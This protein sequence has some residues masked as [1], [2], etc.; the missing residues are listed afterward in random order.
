MKNKAL[1]ENIILGKARPKVEIRTGDQ[2]P[3][4]QTDKQSRIYSLIKKVT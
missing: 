3:G 1:I 2:I 4:L